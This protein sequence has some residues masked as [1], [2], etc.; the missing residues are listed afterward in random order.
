MNAAA[1]HVC[2]PT[3]DSLRKLLSLVGFLAVFLLMSPVNAAETV[4]SPV[5]PLN[6]NAGSDSG[7]D[8]CPDVATDGSGQWVRPRRQDGPAGCSGFSD[9]FPG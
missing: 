6:T 1:E 5:G 3:R 2:D 8:W 9:R 4:F 7:W